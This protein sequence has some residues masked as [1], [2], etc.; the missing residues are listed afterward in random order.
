MKRLLCILS[1]MNAGG[2]ET[3][4]IKM[5]RALDRSK[6]Q[7]DF[8]INETSACF[9]ENEIT[10]LGGKIYRIPTKSCSVCKFKDGLSK[11][12]KNGEYKYVLRITSTPIGFMDV[13]IAKK[14]GATVCAVR[15]SNASEG[16]GIVHSVGNFIGKILY[17]KYVDVKIS[18]S[19]LAAIHT[20]GSKAYKNGEVHILHNAVDLGVYH[21][22]EQARKNIRN[23][24]SIDENAKIIGHIGRFA[25]QKNH[26]FLIDVFNEISKKEPDAVFMIVGKGEL[27]E[28][29]KTKVKDLGL[30]KKVIFT[31]VRTDIPALLSAMDAFVFP[32]FYE[33]M[34]N[35]VIE[36]Q[37]TGLPC[38]ISDSITKEANVTGLVRFLPLSDSVETWSD[39]TLNSI[40]TSDR[41]SVKEKFVANRYDIES[42]VKIFTQIIFGENEKTIDG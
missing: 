1:G 12:V 9:Y 32:S 11:V 5:Y 38:I 16:G 10:S 41:N 15:S 39:T 31:G 23:E 36:A 17:S 34:P 4:L 28:Q 35:T 27:E 3:F 42:V 18:P 37:S 40:G 19:D 30:E 29:I 25:P 6:Y 20:F 14:A 7:M 24:F 33:G 8:C 22:D 26:S 13:K 2:A 21:F